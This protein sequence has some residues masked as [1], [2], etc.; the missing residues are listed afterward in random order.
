MKT[1]K[2]CI[3]KKTFSQII[4]RAWFSW[5]KTQGMIKNP[6]EFLLDDK[7]WISQLFSYFMCYLF[8]LA[9]TKN[10]YYYYII[11]E[12]CT[13]RRTTLNMAPNFL[14]CLFSIFLRK[15]CNFWNYTLKGFGIMLLYLQNFFCNI[16][17]RTCTTVS[18]LK[19]FCKFHFNLPSMS[20]F[21]R[22][23]HHI[24]V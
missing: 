2:K 18:N 8:L 23:G 13:S 17:K 4:W 6:V 22:E 9:K 16:I 15:V 10:Y 19:F 20:M 21:P 14:H 5:I 7:S 24:F 1:R 12:P 11:I 3:L